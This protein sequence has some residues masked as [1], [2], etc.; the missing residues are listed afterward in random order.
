MIII[1]IE[2]T[3]SHPDRRYESRLYQKMITI[4][5]KKG[6]K[7][8]LQICCIIDDNFFFPGTVGTNAD[9]QEKENNKLV[10]VRQGK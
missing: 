9:C 5:I 10:T 6:G 8:M 1:M 2:L 7:K 4:Q 3:S